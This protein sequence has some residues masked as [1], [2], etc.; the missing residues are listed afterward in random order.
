MRLVMQELFQGPERVSPVTV[1]VLLVLAVVPLLLAL[2]SGFTAEG[3]GRRAYICAFV[4]MSLANLVRALGSLVPEERGAL[5]LRL[6]V[7]PLAAMMFVALGVT[8]LLQYSVL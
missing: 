6:A 5:L 8:L 1:R 3:P 4:L 2:S 7:V